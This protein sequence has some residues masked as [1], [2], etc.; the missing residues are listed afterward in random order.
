MREIPSWDTE[1]NEGG[2]TA[3]SKIPRSQFEL[4]RL[5]FIEFGKA[6]PQQYF[7][8]GFHCV[9]GSWTA[10]IKSNSFSV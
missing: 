5:L 6:R 1:G 2:H 10:S 9:A 7:P 4:P 3:G 8:Q